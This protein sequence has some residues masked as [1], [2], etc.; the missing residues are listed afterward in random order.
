MG[1]QDGGVDGLAVL[2]QNWKDD[3]NNV[4]RK[5]EQ[6]NTT[7]IM[8]GLQRLYYYYYEYLFSYSSHVNS[9]IQYT[10]L[11]RKVFKA[12]LCTLAAHS[13]QILTVV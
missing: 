2:S 8:I 5:N 13:E 11:T 1:V 7:T 6:G 10:V 4:R 9:S 12:L 3:K